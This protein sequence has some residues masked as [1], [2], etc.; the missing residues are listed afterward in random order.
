MGLNLGEL[1]IERIFSSAI[2]GAYFREGLLSKFYGSLAQLLARKLWSTRLNDY[3]D[4]PGGLCVSQVNE[5]IRYRKNEDARMGTT[6]WKA[7][8]SR[9]FN[10]VFDFVSLEV[11][12]STCRTILIN[13]ILTSTIVTL[14]IVSFSISSQS[15]IKVSVNKIFFL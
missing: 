9:V 3:K 14:E 2:W 11:F 8:R 15:K 7:G 4:E 6:S 10:L 13:A 1:I 12:P 5:T